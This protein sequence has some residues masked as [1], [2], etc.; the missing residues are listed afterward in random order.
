[1]AA[2]GAEALANGVRECFAKNHA[3]KLDTLFLNANSISPNGGWALMEAVHGTKCRV[4]LVGNALAE[5][6]RDEL[7]NAWGKQVRV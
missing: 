3:A 2:L 5:A 4:W 7:K 1:M 6:E